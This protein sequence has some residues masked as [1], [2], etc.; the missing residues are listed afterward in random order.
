MSKSKASAPSAEPAHL[1]RAP[2][3]V[4][5]HIRRWSE[6][7]HAKLEQVKDELRDELAAQAPFPEV[8]G[9]RK[10]IRMIR[11]YP[12]ELD[13]TIAGM[14]KFLAWRKKYNVDRIRNHIAFGDACQPSNFPHA[15]VV[16]KLAPQII[17]DPSVRDANNYPIGLETY[18]FQAKDVFSSIT[19]DEYVMY[20]V[21][22]C[23]YKSMVLEQV[24]EQA[25]REYLAS[26]NYAPPQSEAGY[27]KVYK[28]CFF[29]D[30]AGIG[31]GHLV[32]QG[33]Q[34][35]SRSLRVAQE[36]YPEMLGKS[37]MLNCSWAFTWVWA[38][39]KQ[40]LHPRTVAKIALYN[41][42]ANIADKLAEEVPRASI[43][44][45][46]GG[47]YTPFNPPITFETEPGGALYCPHAT[48]PTKAEVD[49]HRNEKLCFD[50][51]P[52]IMEDSQYDSRSNTS[53][54]PLGSHL[55][56][57]HIKANPGSVLQASELH[58]AQRLDYDG[59]PTAVA[60]N[61]YSPASTSPQANHGLWARPVG[62]GIQSPVLIDDSNDFGVPVDEAS[63][64]GAR[65]RGVSHLASQAS[66]APP[67]AS[68]DSVPQDSE[69]S[70]HY[71][72]STDSKTA[73]N[74]N[75]LEWMK[76]PFLGLTLEQWSVVVACVLALI[77]ITLLYHFQLTSIAVLPVIVLF[78]QSIL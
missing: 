16:D 24:S 41:S 44:A 73:R 50:N 37:Y 10:L 8:V 77:S 69:S 78:V 22:N 65:Y 48:L 25:E 49:F 13:K 18:Q 67:A 17:C 72:R 34:M 70:L 61:S 62:A 33:K 51:R 32:G 9:D 21:Y 23:E 6:D 35:L 20:L 26:V 30:L 60:E 47:P 14:R 54:T 11:A 58:L 1:P 4:P 55:A 36:F 71:S 28:M 76:A 45:H 52:V 64:S 46:C 53:S 5:A 42:S 63:S 38:L 59:P 39:L 40:F 15:E 31:M 2:P 29:R 7:E 19:I 66:G 43:P 74:L 56:G 12:G 68:P 57:Q 3:A 27:G 75:P